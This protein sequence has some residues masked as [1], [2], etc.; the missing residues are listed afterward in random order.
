MDSWIRPLHKVL[1]NYEA[2]LSA[3]DSLT[4][5]LAARF[6][7]STMVTYKNIEEV[8]EDSVRAV[9]NDVGNLAHKYSLCLVTT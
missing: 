1:H 9:S 4:T 6:L 3:Q 8:L 7:E 2:A 5:V